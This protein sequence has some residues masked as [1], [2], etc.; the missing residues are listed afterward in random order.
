MSEPTGTP[1]P[2]GPGADLPI[3]AGTAAEPKAAGSGTAEPE[4]GPKETGQA[5]ETAGRVAEL[6]DRWL[7][8]VAEVDNV[9]KRAT[10][11]VDRARRDERARVAAEWLPVVDNLD[12]AL[13]HAEGDAGPLVEGVRAVRD[14]AVAV[15]GRLGFPRRDD[16]GAPF[17]PAHHEAVSTV[18]DPGAEPGTVVAVVRPGYGDGAGQLR[19]ASVVVSTR[20]ED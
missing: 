9:R 19:P 10:R 3:P 16:L 11:D 18:E 8:A 2:D 14:Q 15:L 17:D 4:T 20:T 5:E 12:L 7:R 1:R 6:H 13:R